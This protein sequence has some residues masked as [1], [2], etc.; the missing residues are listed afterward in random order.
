VAGGE[1]GEDADAVTSFDTSLEENAPWDRELSARM[2][3]RRTKRPHQQEIILGSA[4]PSQGVEDAGHR[5]GRV[6][7]EEGNAG[8]I[9]MQRIR[10]MTFRTRRPAF[11][12]ALDEYGRRP[13]FTDPTDGPAG[14]YA[15]H[16]A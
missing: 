1:C 11:D 16:S 10:D 15:F 9:W 7:A 4:G 5:A 2:Y 8:L 14:H 13:W 12:D 3:V 6:P